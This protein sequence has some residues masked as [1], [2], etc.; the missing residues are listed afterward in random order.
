[1]GPLTPAALSYYLQALV[2]ENAS[3]ATHCG[4]DIQMKMTAPF[5]WKYQ[6]YELLKY[7]KEEWPFSLS[8]PDSLTFGLYLKRMAL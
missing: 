7:E 3:L 4:S 1:M 6:Q 8:S 2:G 5:Q